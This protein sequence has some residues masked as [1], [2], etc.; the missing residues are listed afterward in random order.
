[1][2]D[3]AGN[4]QNVV[5]FGGNSDIGQAI[6][7]KIP[8]TSTSN[9][10]IVGRN[11]MR[12]DLQARFPNANL[13]LIDF[14]FEDINQVEELI[15]RIFF[16]K[17]IDLAI[18]AY[19]Y[20]GEHGT[21]SLLSETAKQI[22][23]NYFSPA[24]LFVNL[25]KTFHRQKHGKILIISSVAVI[26]PRHSNFVYGSAKSGL[27]FL[28]RGSQDELSENNVSVTILRPGFVHTKMTQGMQSPPFSTTVDQVAADAVRGM[29]RKDKIVYSPNILK[30]VFIILRILPSWIFKK[31]Q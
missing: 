2:L 31:L 25:F 11:L 3:G 24:I 4:F 9:L 5:L 6:L 13:D 26:R 30:Y 28:V 17:D 18:V 21:E 29:L 10:I 22:T 23:I 1:M 20:L 12:N 14:D 7:K 16:R 8:S 15:S 19:G 27:D